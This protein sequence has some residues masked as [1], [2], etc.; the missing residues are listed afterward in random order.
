MCEKSLCNALYKG[1]IT[2]INSTICVFLFSGAGP[3]VP[4]VTIIDPN[5]DT[6][7]ARMVL[8]DMGKSVYKCEYIPT[9]VGNHKV[10]ILFDGIPIP[11]SPYDVRVSHGRLSVNKNL[12]K[13]YELMTYR[14]SELFLD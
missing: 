9:V 11:K 6:N 8:N 12:N 4:T 7:T 14:D 1:H 13:S 3:G 5:G 2:L 10:E